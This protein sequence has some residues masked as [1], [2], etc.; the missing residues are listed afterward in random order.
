MR[1]LRH[2][3]TLSTAE[4]IGFVDLTETVRAW[5]R[6][7]GVRDG[8]LTVTSPH[9]TARLT[10]N[11]QEPR[12][13][14]DMVRFLAQ[15]APADAPYAHNLDTVDDRPN[16]HAH[17]LGLFLNATE[18]IPVADGDLQLGTWQALFFVELDGPR[19]RRTVQLQ[20]LGV[21]A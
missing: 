8:L 5:V 11:E 17:L 14:A 12:L 9:T 4:P 21:A 1:L 2:Q 6:A 16:A 20:L 3:L 13:Q 10:V 7:S 18:T 19:E 15:L